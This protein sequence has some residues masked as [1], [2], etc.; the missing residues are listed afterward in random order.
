MNGWECLVYLGC[1]AILIGYLRWRFQSWRAA[2]LLFAPCVFPLYL[3]LEQTS[4]F[5]TAD[6][7]YYVHQLAGQERRAFFDREISAGAFRTSLSALAPLLG[8]LHQSSAWPAVSAAILVKLCH[9][10]TGFLSFLWLLHLAMN[11]KQVKQPGLFF[12]LAFVLLLLPVG[13]LAL[14]TFN[15]DLLSMNLGL[16]TL[17]YLCLAWQRSCSHLGLLAVGVASLAAQEKLIASPLLLV[18][19]SVCAWLR[20]RQRGNWQVRP[21]VLDTARALLLAWMIGLVSVLLLRVAGGLTFSANPFRLF[22]Q[23]AEPLVVWSWGLLRFTA[24]SIDFSRYF[25]LLLLLTIGLCVA[26][27]LGLAVLQSGRFRSGCAAARRF[28]PLLFLLITG[29][30]VALGVFANYCIP[31]YWAPF[32]PIQPGRFHPPGEINGVVLHYNAVTH[33]HHLLCSVGFAYAVFLDALPTVFW[34]LAAL[35]VFLPTGR[36]SLVAAPLLVAALLVCLLVPLA[37]GLL[38]V[39][40]G[41]RYFNLFLEGAALVLLLLAMPLLARASPPQRW[42][43]A[44]L[45]LGLFLGEVIPFRPLYGA[46]HPF[47]LTFPD[48]RQPEVG[49]INPSWLG[50]GEEMMLVGRRLRSGPAPSLLS[51]G[52]ATPAP[53]TLYCCYYSGAWI[54]TQPALRQVLLHGVTRPEEVSYGPHDYFILNRSMLVQGFPLPD[55]PPD[56]VLSFR[57]FEQAWVY[58]GQRLAASGYAYDPGRRQFVRQT[59]D[60]TAGSLFQDPKQRN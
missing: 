55:L 34:L 8:A 46:F 27:S 60:Q 7:N 57:G 32:H 56:L 24:G 54:T 6:E 48:A 30:A 4:Q 41:H 42:T 29:A 59:P 44:I 26:G 15:Y 11:L 16:V 43:A 33:G 47:W 3:S 1:C 28:V 12:V 13:Q 22:R 25:L 14:K 18:A 58:Q 45:F 23:A 39:P 51:R 53:L 20:A 9:W 10:L 36:Q 19:I 40:L 21:L 31:A 35:L 37:Y 49:R 2:L 5:L 38:Q 52:E 17:A 50:W